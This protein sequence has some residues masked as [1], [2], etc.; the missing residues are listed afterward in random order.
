MV[1]INFIKYAKYSTYGRDS[2][3]FF[4]S[5]YP[6][7]N[8]NYYYN[9]VIKYNFFNAREWANE[10]PHP[11]STGKHFMNISNGH[12]GLYYSMYNHDAEKTR[13]QTEQDMYIR[14]WIVKRAG[15]CKDESHHCEKFSR[16]RRHHHHH[17]PVHSVRNS[18]RHFIS[19]INNDIQNNI[20]EIKRYT[21]CLFAALAV[22]R[23]FTTYI[24]KSKQITIDQVQDL[25]T[26]DN[27]IESNS[28]ESEFLNTQINNIVSIY[29]NNTSAADLNIIYPLYQ[30]LKRNDLALPT[31]QL[32]NIVLWSVQNRSLDSEQTL[33]AI[34]N[35]L[36]NL[37]TV[38]QDVLASGLKP[39]TATFN[40][41][42][43]SLLTGTLDCLKL[44]VA[45]QYQ[46]VTSYKRAQE[47]AQ[48][49]IELFGSIQN[50]SQL[51]LKSLV[52]KL[53][54][55]LNHYP[56]LI[57]KDFV[58]KLMSAVPEVELFTQET[59]RS[60]IELT[61][62]FSRCKVFDGD[63][64]EIYKYIV[65]VYSSYKENSTTDAATNN[66]D[67]FIIYN[68]LIESLISNNQFN[69]A[70]EFLDEILLDFRNSVQFDKKPS[71]VQISNLI[72]TYLEQ[73]DDVYKAY[74]LLQ[75]FN[76]ISYLPELSVSVYNKMINRFIQE[77]S[78]IQL[79]RSK[80][81]NLGKGSTIARNTRAQ[82]LEARQNT[83]YTKIWKLYEHLAIR[84]DFQDQATVEA[85]KSDKTCCRDNLL[86]L[87]IDTG[88]HAR[89]FQLIKEVMAKNHLIYDLHVL[90][91]TL[92]YLYNGVVLNREHGEYFNQYYL[93][94]IWSLIGSQSVHYESNC[95][96]LN[97]FLS[98]FVTYLYVNV[99]IESTSF[100]EINNYNVQLLVNSQIISKAL[101]DFDF[102]SDN[103]FA[104]IVVSKL[105]MGYTGN[106]SAIVNKIVQFQ[107]QLTALFE[108]A[109][110]HYI[111]L[112][113]ELLQFKADLRSSFSKMLT[114]AQDQIQMTNAVSKAC[115]LYDIELSQQTKD[116][117]V[118]SEIQ[119]SYDLNL[120]HLLN[121]NYEIGVAKFINLF[122]QGYNFNGMTWD[123]IVNYNFIVDELEQNFAIKIRDFVQR[124]MESNIETTLKTTLISRLI[125]CNS[126]KVNIKIIEM[127]RDTP[128]MLIVGEYI[129]SEIFF[130]LMQSVQ[131][132][133]NVFLK[134]LLVDEL[135]FRQAFTLTSDKSWVIE[136]FNFL[137]SENK[138]EHLVSLVEKFDV[139]QSGVELSTSQ[140]VLMG[141]YLSALLRNDKLDQFKMIFE[142]TF[143]DKNVSFSNN[144]EFIELLVNYNLALNT[145]ESIQMIV[146]S[147][148]GFEGSTQSLKELVLYAKFLYSLRSE[149]LYKNPIQHAK[150]INE[151]AIRLLSGDLAD[152]DNLYRL[153]KETLLSNKDRKSDLI[154]SMISTLSKAYSSVE[155]KE[156]IIH[157][158]RSMLKFMK[159]AGFTSLS[160]ER[161]NQIIKFLTLT[162]SKEVLNIIMI[163][164]MN[165]NKM[166]DIV[167]FYFLEVQLNDTKDKLRVLKT[168]YN[169][170]RLLEDRINT[171]II[172]DYN[173]INDIR[174][175]KYDRESFVTELSY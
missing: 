28:F 54:A 19:K 85:V 77:F 120:S 82:D 91:K 96:D 116:S 129:E 21:Q 63:S 88:D 100:Q 17:C 166:T 1:F 143:S 38:Y 110:N 154:K 169:S 78:Q 159:L 173:Q 155:N 42:V 161:F 146:S 164:L 71:K 55:V 73:I 3:Q 20:D 122:N 89:I 144:N 107:S 90:K 41:V 158:F 139:V 104:L 12:Y 163:K 58:M 34:E 94:L 10:D 2:I 84:R 140:F 23:N 62:H 115:L 56:E 121:V 130:K 43:D 160:P 103:I 61:K 86:S 145:K 174:L 171:S 25:V 49:S 92:N 95:N 167:N 152:M 125:D 128:E 65:S 29:N 165:D 81:Y 51:D 47:F 123:I 170:F 138:F 52:P 111:E 113:N 16:F 50:V 133:P 97:N 64:K 76:G 53:L 109:D 157:K 74:D 149:S 99:P 124:L 137:A 30:S 69:L 68:G 46:F 83:V 105:F 9:A 66:S 32:Y 72:S 37:L 127:M 48:I 26:P 132:S 112:N 147:Y 11:S 98:E 126:D 13:E 15:Y 153:N 67:E 151:L 87:S 22:S 93:G 4:Q 33:T 150:S 36:T 131:G 35:K 175:P 135:F 40:I 156:V 106:D 79:E 59:Y 117:L 24:P 136:Y 7:L 134:Q 60:L 102:Q 114:E 45:N 101:K 168:L 142:D 108:D 118:N 119:W 39:D 18:T 80:L 8:G 148:G 70:S 75:K 162:G 57:K 141:Q 6:Y 5:S 14:Q 31:I 172:E 44:D 27:A